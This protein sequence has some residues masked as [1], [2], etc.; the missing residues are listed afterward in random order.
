MMLLPSDFKRGRRFVL[1]RK[2]EMRERERREFEIE[3]VRERRKEG[4]KET[5][6]K[7]GQK[8]AAAAETT[9]SFQEREK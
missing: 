3:F 5:D 7:A 6:I 9:A 8:E 1:Q 4:R 2:E